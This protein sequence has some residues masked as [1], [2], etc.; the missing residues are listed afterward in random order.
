MSGWPIQKATTVATTT[1]ATTIQ[2][3]ALGRVKPNSDNGPDRC[4][5]IAANEI[6]DATDST[7][8]NNNVLEDMLDGWLGSPP[9]PVVKMSMSSWMRWSG[10]SMVWSMKRE[11]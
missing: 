11:R 3:S 2:N 6:T 5:R 9:V 1:K 4:H 10:L 7:A 8:P